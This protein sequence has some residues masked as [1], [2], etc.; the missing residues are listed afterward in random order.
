MPLYEYHCQKCGSH[1]EKI[2]RFADPPLTKCEKCGGKLEQ[3]LSSPAIQFKG[4]GFYINDYGKKPAADD[5]KP[6]KPGNGKSTETAKAGE[7][8]KS[9]ETS[10]TTATP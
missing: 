4:S 9:A 3:L 7:T 1:F 8:T 10:K 5:S 2:R 6:S